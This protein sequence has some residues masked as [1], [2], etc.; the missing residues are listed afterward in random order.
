[1]SDQT[2]ASL[3][4]RLADY[5]VNAFCDGRGYDPADVIDVGVT[6]SEGFMAVLDDMREDQEAGTATYDR[7]TNLR[8]LVAAAT[9]YRRAWEGLRDNENHPI[10]DPNAPRNA[11]IRAFHRQAVDDLLKAAQLPVP[12]HP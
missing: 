3:N 5:L 11:G 8:Q 7:E 1:M 9:Q 6:L 2:V 10:Y 12:W 4:D